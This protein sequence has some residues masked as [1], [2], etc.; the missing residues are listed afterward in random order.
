M[1]DASFISIY[2]ALHGCV[3]YESRSGDIM[4]DVNAGW[5]ALLQLL[6]FCLLHNTP[7]R[8]YFII[9]DICTKRQTQV[10]CR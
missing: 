3:S 10:R 7:A 2:S 1:F 9:D 5:L 8:C 6:K 4:V